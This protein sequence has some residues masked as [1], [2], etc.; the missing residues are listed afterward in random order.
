MQ[1]YANAKE[2]VHPRKVRTSVP[3]FRA[4]EQMVYADN[5]RSWKG[6][7]NGSSASQ[8]RATMATYVFPVLGSLAVDA[9]TTADVLKV[10]SPIWGEKQTTAKRAA[11]WTSQVMRRTKAVGYRMDD[12]VE[13]AVE[14]L[15]KNRAM[16]EHHPAVSY[17]EVAEVLRKVRETGH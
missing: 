14:I 11:Q 1:N 15:L 4:V 16:P 12:P 5:T 6:G 3:D 9:I 2:G 7:S 13:D 17:A 8:W 10:L